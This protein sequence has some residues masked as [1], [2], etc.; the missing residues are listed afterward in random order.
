MNNNFI[1]LITWLIS[2][3]YSQTKCF[4]PFSKELVVD[5]LNTD[6]LIECLVGNTL[7]IMFDY[8]FVKNWDACKFFLN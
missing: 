6:C 2:L 3:S 7:S 5:L 8:F 4:I 1:Q